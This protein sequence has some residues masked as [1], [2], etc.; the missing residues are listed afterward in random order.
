MD[1]NQLEVL[2]AVAQEKSFS[3]AAEIL[4][5]TQP[6][7]SQAIRRLEIE[8]GEKLF[9]RSSKDGT[10]T[11]AGEV[12]LE[13]AKQMMNLRQTAHLA[14]KELRNLQ[15]GKVT[16]SANE[17]TVFYLLPVICEFRRRFP[18]IK[19]EVRRGVASRIPT[20]V[21][22][23]ETE[24]GIVS[25]KPNDDS[26][27]SVAVITDELTLVVSPKHHLANKKS[28]SIKEL[29][30][31]SFIAHNAA[32]PYRHKVIETFEKYRTPLN[33]AI[34][35]PS[36]EAI[37]HMVELNAGIAFVPKLTA[38]NELKTG[39]LK[40]LAVNEMRLERKLHI[41]YRRNSVLSQAAQGFLEV[42][43]EFQQ[44]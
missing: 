39:Q 29:G 16:L 34:E 33:I 3:R 12:L 24:L 10:L 28:V 26:V 18:L 36:L 11:A 32:S 43:R 42:A 19:I 1:I 14:I 40:G 21:M 9:D 38:E 35:L 13:Y 7:V 17:H 5:R 15:K 44:T 27:K 30:S 25:F 20:E 8:I 6:A 31:E 23:R 37:K 41:I 4:N 2:V 22:A